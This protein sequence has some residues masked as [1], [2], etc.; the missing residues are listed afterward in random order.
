MWST[1]TLPL[2]YGSS[3]NLKTPS[4]YHNKIYLFF[5]LLMFISGELITNKTLNMVELILLTPKR[6]QC[7]F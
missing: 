5:K 4:M 6:S 2:L 3:G 7:A 1:E